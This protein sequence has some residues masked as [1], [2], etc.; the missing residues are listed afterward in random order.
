MRILH[1]SDWH[2]GARLHEQ[3]RIAEHR[4]FLAELVAIAERE[5]VEAL[6]VAG[7]VFDTR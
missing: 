6:L 7:D 4:Q 3:E 5:A 1:T 2:L